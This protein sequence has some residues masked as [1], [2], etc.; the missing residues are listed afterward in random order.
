VP[1]DLVLA[2]GVRAQRTGDAATA[3]RA[4]RE[5][6]ASNPRDARAVQLLGALLVERG[7]LD[8]A[9]EWFERV[10]DDVGPPAQETLGFYN[11]YANALRRAQ[12]VPSAE[13]ILRELVRIAPRDWQP[14]HNLGQTLKDMERFD[15]AAAALRRAV[16][17]EPDFGPNHGVLG[18]VLH[19]LGRLQSADASLRRCLALGWTADSA[20]W[21]VLANNQR[22]LGR[23]DEALDHVTRALALSGGHPGAHSNIGVIL[24][25]LG[26][27]DDA[28]E[29]FHRALAIDPDHSGYHGYLAYTLLA[30][31]RLTE[32]FEH[33]ELGMRGGPRGHERKLGVPRWTPADRDARVM[34]YREQGVGDEIMM[35]SCYPDLVAAAREVVIECDPRV[36]PLFTR[37]F[38]AAEVRAQTIDAL[39]RETAHD[40]DRVVPAG[41]LMCWFRPSVEAFGDRRTLL[42]ADGAKV[43]AWRARLAAAGPP[44]Y[45]GIS[46]RSKVRTA[47][48]RFHYTRL[49]EWG[50]IFATP[51]VTWVNLQYDECER[52]LRDAEE[53]FG[54]RVQRWEWLD[55]MND[56]DEVAALSCAL[57]LVVAPFNAVS[58]LSGALGVP[59]VAMGNR[60]GWSLLGTERLPWLPA[61]KVALRMPHEE[62]DEV[63][64]TAAQEV[65]QVAARVGSEATRSTQ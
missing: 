23:L 56:F 60:H 42:V 2:S 6:L 54:V 41:S 4:F 48:R 57:D 16:M 64:A 3:E 15:E 43:E 32:A 5:V 30:A 14:W 12:R 19:H 31:G 39:Q 47:E 22:L 11:N 13:K 26:R 7:A 49:D 35:A 61:V 29:H 65:A 24:T 8:E 63:L 46:W 51:G 17:L 1:A 58:M 38:P 50:G 44:P 45:V 27:F 59:T 21:T 52:E 9:L 37:S 25:Q 53:R 28:V 33:W 34:V 36:V 62:W 20:A 55:L 40:F 10:L 18:E